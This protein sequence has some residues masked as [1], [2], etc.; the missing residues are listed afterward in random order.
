MAANSIFPEPGSSGAAVSRWAA[1]YLVLYGIG[2]LV[3]GLIHVFL[4]DGG[5]GSIA[6]IDFGSSYATIRAL[7]AWAGAGQVVH[8]LACIVVGL[9]Y[10]A[11]VPLFLLLGLIERLLMAWS[12][13]IAHAPPGGHHPPGHYG[14]LIALPLLAFFLWLS[15]RG[16]RGS[17]IEIDA[18]RPMI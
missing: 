7:F 4:P 3:P 10:R 11:L 1:G 9:R 13:W 16:R 15:L 2:W 5:A 14:H 8:G 17:E 12:A 6:G 18:D